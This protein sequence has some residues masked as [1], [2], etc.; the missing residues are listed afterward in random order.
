[1][2]SMLPTLNDFGIYKPGYIRKVDKRGHWKPEDSYDLESR[3]KI[4]AERIFKLNSKNLYSLWY[5]E[6]AE[7]F[8]GMVA[9]LSAGRTPKNQDIDFLWIDAEELSSASIEPEPVPEG[10]CLFVQS[11]HFNAYIDPA[12]AEQLCLIMMQADREAQR[13][14]KRQH[15]KL[16][17]EYQAEKGCKDTET[18]QENCDCEAISS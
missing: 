10:Q 11:M 16:I 3:A 1:D 5:V 6:T 4:A 2:Q 7:Q 9:V 17:L 13:C 14:K 8:Y 18:S 12:A 15:T